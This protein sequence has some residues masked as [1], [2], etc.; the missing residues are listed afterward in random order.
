VLSKLYFSNKVNEALIG[1]LKDL[2]Q[3]LELPA[4]HK[5]LMDEVKSGS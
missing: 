3:S 1:L 2:P 4:Y 5:M